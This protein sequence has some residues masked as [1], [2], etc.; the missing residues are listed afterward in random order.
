MDTTSLT[1]FDQ[2]RLSDNLICSIKT[3]TTSSVLH[4]MTTF[5]S[6]S[7]FEATDNFPRA[8]ARV[9]FSQWQEWQVREDEVE[10]KRW[11]FNQ[12]RWWPSP[13]PSV[14]LCDVGSLTWHCKVPKG[15]HHIERVS[16]SKNEQQPRNVETAD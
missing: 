1:M 11:P 2:S 13:T 9:P 5:S 10:Q 3:L 12:T 16:K 7:S 4:F 15:M 6:S 14:C 8:W